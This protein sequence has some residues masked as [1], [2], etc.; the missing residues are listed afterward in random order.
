VPEI[1]LNPARSR[2]SASLEL[3]AGPR[4]IEANLG[5]NVTLSGEV[6]FPKVVTSD[7]AMRSGARTGITGEKVPGRR[8]IDRRGTVIAA[9][10]GAGPGG[11]FGE[12]ALHGPWLLRWGMGAALGGAVLAWLWDALR[13]R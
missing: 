5:V 2:S 3:T 6:A 11:T 1:P 8:Q 7:V 4:P 12:H 9:V 10:T 13:P